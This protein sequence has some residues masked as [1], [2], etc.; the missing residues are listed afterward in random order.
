MNFWY[1]LNKTW[2]IKHPTLRDNIKRREK[3]TIKKSY[4]TKANG[5]HQSEKIIKEYAQQP[6]IAII[7]DKKVDYQWY[8]KYFSKLHHYNYEGQK[9]QA[10]QPHQ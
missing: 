3:N 6:H 4:N 9:Y 8:Q 2:Y 1:L 7:G 5:F 10:L